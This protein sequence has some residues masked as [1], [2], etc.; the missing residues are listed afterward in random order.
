MCEFGNA[1]RYPA[2]VPLMLQPLRLESHN[3]LQQ[4]QHTQR[5]D[6]M[7]GST[8]AAY[9]ATG[10]GSRDDGLHTIDLKRSASSAPGIPLAEMPSNN[11]NNNPERQQHTTVE[12]SMAADEKTSDAEPKR[13]AWGNDLEFLMSCIALS[14]GLGNV[15]RF[16]F[17]AL[18]NGGGAFLIPYLVVLLLVGKPIYYLEMLVGQFGGRGSINVYDV[19]PLMRGIGYGQLFAVAALLSYYAALLALTVRYFLASFKAVLPWSE[20]LDEWGETCVDST[21]K[22]GLGNL[23]AKAQTSAEFYF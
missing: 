5:C 17:A 7:D 2:I 15:W 21:T 11:N 9:T 12:C 8:N 18:E 14:V 19:V 16:P 23:T 22:M 6:I 4:S 20:C 1:P 10:S 3:R 13:D